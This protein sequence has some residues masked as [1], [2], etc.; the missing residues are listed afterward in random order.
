MNHRMNPE[1][2]QLEL[3]NDRPHILFASL[4]TLRRASFEAD[5]IR[6]ELRT[7]GASANDA[8]RLSFLQA[9]SLPRALRAPLVCR[10]VWTD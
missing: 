9:S 6:F 8:T 1:H 2:A 3:V 10:Y 5:V 7:R 4:D